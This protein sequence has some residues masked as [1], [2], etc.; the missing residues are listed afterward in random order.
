MLGRSYRGQPITWK[1]A[2]LPPVDR[3]LQILERP[4]RADL[5][6]TAPGA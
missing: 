3:A 6:S 2:Y 5:G 1:R 4:A